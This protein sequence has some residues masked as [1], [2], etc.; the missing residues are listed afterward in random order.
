MTTLFKS[1]SDAGVL[2]NKVE[3]TG[4]EI[5]GLTKM[6]DLLTCYISSLVLKLFKDEKVDLYRR[7]LQQFTVY[8]INNAHV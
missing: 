5:A 1:S 6:I 2:A 8:E 7:L 3:N 4:R